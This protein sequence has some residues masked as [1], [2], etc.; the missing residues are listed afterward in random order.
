MY[1]R[2]FGTAN[3]DYVV[4]ERYGGTVYKR[5]SERTETPKKEEPRVIPSGGEVR[6]SQ[7]AAEMHEQDIRR[8]TGEDAA[9]TAD[10]ESD[11]TEPADESAALPNKEKSAQKRLFD[12][13]EEELFLIGLMI[14]MLSG[15]D[16]PQGTPDKSDDKV[17]SEPYTAAETAV[18]TEEKAAPA[19]S[20]DAASSSGDDIL[21]PLLLALL[22]W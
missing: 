8:I 7:K 16:L 22:I 1:G 15:A 18:P 5:P 2:S 19:V 9:K 3:G 17:G 20:S 13:S 10:A 6:L 4:P 12:I 11:R 14:L 21:I